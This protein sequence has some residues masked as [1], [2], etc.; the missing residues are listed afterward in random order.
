MAGSFRFLLFLCSLSFGSE[1]LL[2]KTF[3]KGITFFIY[4]D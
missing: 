3:K 1:K 2:I 4:A